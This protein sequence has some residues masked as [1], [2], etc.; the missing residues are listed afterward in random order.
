MKSSLFWQ[1]FE[2]G[3]EL[4]V[5]AS[6]VYDGLN[7]LDNMDNF[8][9]ESEIFQFLYNVSVGVERF[10]KVAIILSEF[11][12]NDDAE[13]FEKSLITHNHSELLNR[14]CQNNNLNLSKPHKEFIS[15]LT[16][17]YK[18]YRYDRYSLATIYALSKEKNALVDFLKTNLNLEPGAYIFETIY[19][20][21]S[22]TK[23]FIGKII[24]K[25]VLQI[26]DIIKTQASRKN[27][28]TDEIRYGS[29]AYKLLLGKQFDFIHEDV[30][31]KELLIFILNTQQPSSHLEFL[32][33]VEPLDFDVALIKDYL[34]SFRSNTKKILVTDEL[35]S[36]YQDLPDVNLRFSIIDQVSNPEYDISDDEL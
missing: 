26:F 4:E 18:S 2:L 1:N 14:L 19:D 5:A 31:W 36:L 20:N 24:S 10:F 12:D 9:F 32:K 16:T 7:C 15:I 22:R 8:H 11:N 3:I 33:S 35:E 17:F 21:D 29:K 25:I 28:Y 30:L 34:D 13:A 23:K 27:I 6:F